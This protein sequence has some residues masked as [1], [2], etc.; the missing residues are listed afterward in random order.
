LPI[1]PGVDVAADAELAEIDPPL[2]PNV[3]CEDT[4]LRLDSLAV[5]QTNVWR[6]L[7]SHRMQEPET[8]SVMS[9]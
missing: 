8:S 6:R 3:S 1:N 2:Y 9:F 4:P 7:M 5:P